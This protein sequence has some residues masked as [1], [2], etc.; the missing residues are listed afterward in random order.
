VIDVTVRISAKQRVRKRSEA[1]NTILELALASLIMVPCCL[2]VAGLGMTLGNFI[3]ISQIV[4][5]SAH[6]FARGIDFDRDEN[7]DIILRLAS[8]MNVTRTG[9]DGIVIFSKII[10]PSQQD[11]EAANRANNCPNRNVPVLIHRVTIGQTSVR[12]SQFGTPNSNLINADGNI[13]SADYLTQSSAIATAFG[14]ELT[15][16]GMQQERGD[17]PYL[18]E[19]YFSLPALRFLGFA[20][21]GAYCRY[22][23]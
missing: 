1:G 4:R 14:A 13:T 7:K 9:G 16:A 18:V 3:R 21:T 6:M 17:I 5:D 20:P 19:G 8:S 10:T 22:I 23:F 12:A 11:C 2:G 15:R